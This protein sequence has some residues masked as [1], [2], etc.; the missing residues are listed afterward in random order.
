MKT[1]P[2]CAEEI[3]DAA[4]V[5][6]HCG[7]DLQARPIEKPQEKSDVSRGFN[8]TCGVLL[9]LFIV[10]V[11]LPVG[12]CVACGTGVAVLGTEGLEDVNRRL[13][14]FNERNVSQLWRE[15]WARLDL[16]EL[17]PPNAVYPK[18]FAPHLTRL[19]T[20]HYRIDAWF[21]GPHYMPEVGRKEFTCELKHGE[22]AK[23]T[24]IKLEVHE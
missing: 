18:S 7:R 6:K 19:G 21:E 11:V 5:C 24:I 17:V 16:E 9:A 1:C 15:C 13:G 10:F 20:G 3:Q 23:W 2:H 14:E 12:A 22:D 8:A 4:V